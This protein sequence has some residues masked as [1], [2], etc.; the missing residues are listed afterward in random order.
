[1]IQRPPSSLIA[2]GGVYYLS[3]IPIHGSYFTDLLP[4][5]VARSIGLGALIVAVTTAANAGVPAEKAGLAA[6]LLN[7]S[8]QIGGGALRLA[9]FAAIATSHTS[10]LLSAHTAM[11]AALTAGFHR[12]IL[13]SSI[14][15]VIAA[16]IATRTSN[17][18]S[19]AGQD[20]P[21]LQPQPEIRVGAAA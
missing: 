7:A 5:L 3:R 10:H 18:R 14:S 21:A 8:Q 12:A 9:I 17:T 1:V 19:E 16:V 6:A 2:A 4:G 15:L 13:P 20:V 11:P